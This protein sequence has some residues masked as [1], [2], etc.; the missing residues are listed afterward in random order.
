M[1]VVEG[2]PLTNG[3][4]CVKGF[5]VVVSA[6][7]ECGHLATLVHFQH[8]LGFCIIFSITVTSHENQ[9]LSTALFVQQ[10]VQAHIKENIK[11]SVSQVFVREFHRSWCIPLTKAVNAV[12]VPAWW[13]HQMETLSALLTLYAGKSPIT[14]EFSSQRP[15]TRSFDVF[16]D[17]RLNKRLSKQ[18]RRQWLETPLPS[19]WRHCNVS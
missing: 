14:G 1:S 2:V 5:H 11:L 8:N 6:W 4:L 7:I 13:R 16:L 18:S 3:Q 9:G 12:N 19:F 15:V 17:L 10:L